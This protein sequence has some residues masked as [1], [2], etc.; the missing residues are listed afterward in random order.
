MIVNLLCPSEA[1][2]Q[3]LPPVFDP[4]L[5]SGEP[6]A[7]LKKEFE[8]PKAPPPA[9][10]LPPAPLPPEGAIEPGAP[11]ISVFVKGIK[12][13]GSTVFSQDDL[14]QVTSP[15]TNRR[16]TSEEL[17]QLRLALSLLYVRNGYV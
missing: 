16:I 17:E 10:V 7:P 15:Y 6:H 3:A 11:P 9:Q 2:A 14:A 13:V 8:P 1:L 12:V 4:S 5:R